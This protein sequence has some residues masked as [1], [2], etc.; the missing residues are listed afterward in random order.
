MG[1]KQ[2]ILKAGSNKNIINDINICNFFTFKLVGYN[3]YIIYQTFIDHGIN[4]TNL[5]DK[6]QFG[7]NIEQISIPIAEA[8]IH[9]IVNN[10]RYIECNCHV[11]DPLI[12]NNPNPNN[13][14]ELNISNNLKI[15][16]KLFIFILYFIFLINM[17]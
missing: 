11:P 13:N 10:N 7:V 5:R 3:N 16:K 12:N 17:F 9:A 2:C 8:K 4:I 1:N 15:N 6:L 14:N